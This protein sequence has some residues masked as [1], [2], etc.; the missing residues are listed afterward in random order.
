MDATARISKTDA[1]KRRVLQYLQANYPRATLAEL[2]RAAGPVGPYLS[3][4]IRDHFQRTFQSLLLETRLERARELLEGNAC[5]RRHHPPGGLCENGSYFTAVL[6]EIRR[7]APS[8]PQ[9]VCLPKSGPPLW[10]ALSFGFS[11]ADQPLVELGAF[12]D[13]L[14]RAMRSVV[15]V[16]GGAVP[17][18]HLKGREAQHV[19]ADGAKRRESLQ[20]SMT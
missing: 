2:A 10:A 3:K 19:V 13:L 11:S 6:G 12:A 15:G 16:D 14:P 5:P 8:I 17:L 9:R 7:H 20:A 18:A 1:Q 4:W